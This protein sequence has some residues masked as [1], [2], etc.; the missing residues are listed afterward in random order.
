M[1]LV[2]EY[3][4]GGEWN[5]EVLMDTDEIDTT[6]HHTIKTLFFC[7]T[8]PEVKLVMGEIK[9]RNTKLGGCGK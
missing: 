6:K 8:W 9:N 2:I 7:E 1:H 5:L 3:E 4:Q